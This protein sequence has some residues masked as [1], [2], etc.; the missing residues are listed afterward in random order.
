MDSLLITSIILLLFI[1]IFVFLVYI[2]Q[3]DQLKILTEITSKYHEID[4]LK[5]SIEKM[6]NDF[7]LNQSTVE[8][9]LIGLFNSSFN[10][11]KQ[12]Q[13]DYAKSIIIQI[14]KSNKIYHDE[15]IK[16]L[17]ESINKLDNL[18]NDF[19]TY[20]NNN[21]LTIQK[22]EDIFNNFINQEQNKVNDLKI[23]LS[24][25]IEDIL[26]EIKNPHDFEEIINDK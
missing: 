5:I 15:F 6:N 2:R 24:N 3:N 14:S 18:N 10:E 1:A 9:N 8:Q 26:N 12:K 21:T 16:Y 7:I 19:S 17:I 13:N 4:N 25:K 20:S 11:I 23:S 22:F